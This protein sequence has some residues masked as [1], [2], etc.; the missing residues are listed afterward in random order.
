MK[1]TL[2]DEVGDIAQAKGLTRAEIARKGKFSYIGLQ[3]LLTGERKPTLDALQRLAR[4]LD[5]S[6]WILI[7]AAIDEPL[8][9]E[10]YITRPLNT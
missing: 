1:R 10:M 8:P 7:S 3:M 6:V 9:P 4:G 2:K 5:V